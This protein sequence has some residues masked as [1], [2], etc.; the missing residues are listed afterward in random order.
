MDEPN[1][2]HVVAV[3][4]VNFVIGEDHPLLRNNGSPRLQNLA[5]AAVFASYL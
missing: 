1:H 2:E 3:Y 4:F 5:E